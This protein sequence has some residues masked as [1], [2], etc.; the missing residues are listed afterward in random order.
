[1]APSLGALPSLRS[2]SVAVRG[3]VARPRNPPGRPLRVR[4]PPRSFLTAE[5]RARS[6]GMALDD[7][8]RARI[9][10]Y[11][12]SPTADVFALWGLPE[13]VIAVLFAYYSRSKDDLRT[14]LARLLA[15]EELAVTGP[16]VV[17]GSAIVDAVGK[18][19]EE[20]RDPGEAVHALVA[21]LAQ[22]VRSA[23]RERA[24]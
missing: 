7:A 23:I 19:A 24:A 9:A 6:G 12:S 22:A 15:D 18:A 10:P 8:S 14:N 1:M 5:L 20:G 11:V 17:V 21:P 16:G 13:E 2:L 3:L 4:P